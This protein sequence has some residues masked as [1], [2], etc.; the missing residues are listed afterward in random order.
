MF[1]YCQEFYLEFGE[2]NTT[3]S[4]VVSVNNAHSDLQYLYIELFIRNS[5]PNYL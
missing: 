5:E 4:E 1:K 3:L 2:V